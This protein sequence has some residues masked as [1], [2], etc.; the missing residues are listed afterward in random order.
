MEHLEKHVIFIFIGIITIGVL[1]STQVYAIS[2][3][4]NGSGVGTCNVASTWNE[5]Q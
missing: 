5:P 1:L 2:V 4:S 3:E